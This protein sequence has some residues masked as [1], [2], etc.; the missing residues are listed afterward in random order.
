MPRAF[1]IEGKDDYSTSARSG[2]P[3]VKET[4][5]GRRRLPSAVRRR[6]AA[7][8]K[9]YPTEND[10]KR[11]AQQRAL[12]DDDTQAANCT[13]GGGPQACAQK[14]APEQKGAVALSYVFVAGQAAA[15]EL[16][17]AQLAQ[18]LPASR[19]CHLGAARPTVCSNMPRSAANM[20]LS[21]GLLRNFEVG[22][23]YRVVLRCASVLSFRSE[24]DVA[25]SSTG[26]PE[27]GAISIELR[28]TPSAGRP[29][30][31]CKMGGPGSDLMDPGIALVGTALVP[32]L[33]L[34]WSRTD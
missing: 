16:C 10:K 6:R 31:R 12:R 5:A 21:G 34:H 1:T 18:V 17:L 14:A 4:P 22:Y 7:K 23:T 3:P 25:V 26:Q 29:D 8:H 20:W 2:R 28:A 13:V 24:G 30:F 15:A 27:V 32:K 33:V 9:Q 19:S 11:G